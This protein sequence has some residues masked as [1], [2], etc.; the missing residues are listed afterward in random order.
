MD[1]QILG[2]SNLIIDLLAVGTLLLILFRTE[3]SL[4][5]Q[6]QI[7]FFK[8]IVIGLALSALTAGVFSLLN[9][10]PRFSNSE[11]CQRVNVILISIFI[12]FSFACWTNLIATTMRIKWEETLWWK[13]ATAV[14]SALAFLFLVTPI[15]ESLI[16]VGDNK[17]PLVGAGYWIITGIYLVYLALAIASIIKGRKVLRRKPDRRFIISAFVFAGLLLI[18]EV[19]STI[20][21]NTPAFVVMQIPATFFIF[22]EFQ[23]SQAST[24]ALTDLYNRRKIDDFLQNAM[25]QAAADRPVELYFLDIDYFKSINDILGHQAGDNALQIFSEAL[26]TTAEYRGTTIGRW[27][28]DEFV[29]I[30]LNGACDPTS[31]INSFTKKLAASKGLGYEMRFSYGWAVC[32]DANVTPEELTKKADEALYRMKEKHHGDNGLAFQQILKGVRNG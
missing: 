3:S 31:F 25:E 8:L 16:Q 21:A 9:C 27:G 2:L 30:S 19:L 15:S 11:N 14:P 29:V 26:M 7:L 23:S 1:S 20:I 12:S 32:T 13:L 17:L 10:F 28:G 5:R 22:S 24:D 18:G 4:G 6:K